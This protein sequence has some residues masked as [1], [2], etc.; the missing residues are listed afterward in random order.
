MAD[1]VVERLSTGCSFHA[2]L[3][4]V[5]QLSVPHPLPGVPGVPGYFQAR[6]QIERRNWYAF[7]FAHLGRPL[8]EIAGRWNPCPQ[9]LR[10]GPEHKSQRMTSLE[11]LLFE[12]ILGSFRVESQ[13][14]P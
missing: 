6:S 8:G 11:V 10:I 4:A 14:H 5:V 13:P 12:D 7:V 1:A 2:V 9:R 3:E